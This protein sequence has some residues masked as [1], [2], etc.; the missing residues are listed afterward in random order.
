ME[1]TEIVPTQ[2]SSVVD[3]FVIVLNLLYRREGITAVDDFFIPR[4]GG[5]LMYIGPQTEI[6]QATR[7]YLSS[8][9]SGADLTNINPVVVTTY[10]E[11][12]T[13]F[14]CLNTFPYLSENRH[15]FAENFTSLLQIRQGTRFA[16]Y[17]REIAEKA[18]ELPELD[19][20]DSFLGLGLIKL[21]EEINL[22]VRTF[23]MQFF[24]LENAQLEIVI[25]SFLERYESKGSSG[26]I[27]ETTM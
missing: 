21:A 14:Y 7:E 3:S 8:M 16:E 6:V 10:L 24:E 12:L 2:R 26:I 20:E 11:V 18:Q 17:F 23:V 5:S 4:K 1:S 19:R 15:F 13:F 9:V 22:V 25:H 27:A